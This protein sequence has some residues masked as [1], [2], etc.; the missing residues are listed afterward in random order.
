MRVSP[1]QRAI[2][3][4]RTRQRKGHVWIVRLNI[5]LQAVFI[6]FHYSCFM[7]DCARRAVIS[8][9]GVEAN[10]GVERFLNSD[11]QTV[12]QNHK[13]HDLSSRQNI[14]LRKKKKTGESLLR[15]WNQNV[16]LKTYSQ[17]LFSDSQKPTV[18]AGIDLS[19]CLI[20][21]LLLFNMSPG[22]NSCY[23]GTRTARLTSKPTAFIFIS[24]GMLRIQT[25][26]HLQQ[27][28]ASK[29]N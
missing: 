9:A 18:P 24:L 14:S 10:Q 28:L 20:F 5:G 13:C 11:M 16:A 22:E 29:I 26:I 7:H 23:Y 15:K 3:H 21:L 6:I 8:S 27:I 2:V 12:Q 25:V 4:V 19:P 1:L 17:Y